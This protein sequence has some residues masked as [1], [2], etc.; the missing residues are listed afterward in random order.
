MNFV[1]PDTWTAVDGLGRSVS[2]YDKV[3][4]KKPGKFVGCFYWLWYEIWQNYQP[5]NITK[6][7]Q[8]HPE[9]RNDFDHPAWGEGTGHGTPYYWNEP[10]LGYYRITDPYVIRKHA[11]LLADAGVDVLFFDCSNDKFTFKDSYEVFFRELEAAKKDGVQV[12]QVAFLLNFDANENTRIQLTDLW[13][14]IYSKGRYQDLWFYWEGKPLIMAH[15]A[16]L[17]SNDETQKA[18]LDFFTFRRNEPTYFFRDTTF[19]EKT[20]GWCSSYP[21]A[22]YGVREDGSCEQMCVSVGQN[23]NEHGL[24]S[25]N[26]YRGGVQGRAFA[27]GDY[28]Y[29]YTYQDET[30]TVDKAREDA[31]LYGLNFQQQWDRALEANPDFIFVT[32]WNEH[33][34]QR[35]REWMNSPNGFSDNFNDQYSRDIEPS[36]GVLKDHFYYQLVENIRRFKGVSA[37]EQDSSA[38][39]TVDIFAREDAW[40]DVALSYDHYVGSTKKRDWDGAKGCH[41]TSDT[42]RNDIVRSKV[43]YDDHFVY[44]MVE[45]ASDLTP[46]S[47]PAWMRLLIQIDATCKMPNWEGFNFIV[48]RVSPSGDEAV[49]ERSLGGWNFEQVETARFSVSGKRLQIAIPRALIGTTFNFKWADNTRAD[50]SADDSGDILDFYKY[51]DVAPGGRFL[52]S[53]KAK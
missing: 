42:M 50:G 1:K 31:F 8:E 6:I 38:N 36:S 10:L 53:F 48:N 25:M 32:G 40:K 27:K 34:C 19:D 46:A 21:Q 15:S 51:G 4:E 44:F 33:V 52:F 49:V 24:V 37:P 22:K 2:D 26:D 29:N 17:D 39:K 35:L 9:A 43:A 20:W 28:S 13:E 7:I 30:V 45:T 11:E 23:A 14:T 3:G 5:R 12:P 41:Y 47:D 18:I 16:K